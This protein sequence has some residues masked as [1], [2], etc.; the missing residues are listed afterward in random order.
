MRPKTI[1]AV[2]FDLGG[3]LIGIDLDQLQ[4]EPETKDWAP[5]IP[6]MRRQPETVLLNRGKMPPDE[7]YQV[8]RNRFSLSGSFEEFRRAWC[9]IFTPRPPM[10]DLVRR[11]AGRVPLGLLSDTEP[12]HW[13]YLRRQYGFLELFQKPVLSFEAGAVKPAAKMYQLAAESV[14]VPAERCFYIDDLPENVEGARRAGMNAAVFE[15]AEQVGA[16]L[17]ESGICF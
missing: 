2:I 8:M 5:L 14:G 4:K 11:L 12:M 17:K 13:D 3:V 1:G 16:F 7:F 9:G 15:S 10:E 6:E